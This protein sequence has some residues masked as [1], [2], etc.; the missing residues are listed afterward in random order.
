MVE[1]LDD[2]P[3]D[4]AS[5]YQQGSPFLL[6]PPQAHYSHYRYKS[7]LTAAFGPTHHYDK[8]DC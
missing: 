1:G 2:G 5:T 8:V 4:G 7:C 6:F 3:E